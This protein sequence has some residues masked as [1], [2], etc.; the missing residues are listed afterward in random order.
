MAGQLQSDLLKII[1]IVT[2][3]TFHLLLCPKQHNLCLQ[4]F[5]G[6]YIGTALSTNDPL[7]LLRIRH[8]IFTIELHEQATITF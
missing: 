1:N 6:L 5:T 8:M 4:A 3:V 7:I 2:T